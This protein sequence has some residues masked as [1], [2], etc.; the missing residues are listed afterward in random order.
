MF[1]NTIFA[2]PIIL[3]YLNKLKGEVTNLC[4]GIQNLSE[5]LFQQMW[6]FKKL[7]N[8]SISSFLI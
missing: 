2:S 6:S 7:P 4:I 3:F 5:N 1:S 8:A